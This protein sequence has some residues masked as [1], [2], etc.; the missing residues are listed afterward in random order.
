MKQSSAAASWGGMDDPPLQLFLILPAPRGWAVNLGT[1]TIAVYPS[2]ETARR[3]A[4]EMAQAALADG[5]RASYMDP[6]LAARLKP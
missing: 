5:E 2:R 1:D 3:R 6:G 4:M